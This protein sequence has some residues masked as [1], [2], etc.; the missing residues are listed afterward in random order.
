MRVQPEA[1]DGE[2]P[3]AFVGEDV[4]EQLQR[5]LHLRVEVLLGEGELS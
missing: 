5:V 4:R 2:L 3:H 1:V